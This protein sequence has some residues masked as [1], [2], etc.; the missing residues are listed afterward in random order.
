MGSKRKDFDPVKKVIGGEEAEAVVWSTNS[1]N[2]A[3]DAISKGLPLKANPFVGKNTKLLKPDLVYNRTE[4]EIEDYIHCMNDMVYFA[5]KCYLMTPKGLAPVKLRDYQEDYLRHLSKNRFSLFLSCRQSGKTLTL[6]NKINISFSITYKNEFADLLRKYPFYIK[7]NFYYIDNIPIYEIY[8]HYNKDIINKIRYKLYKSINNKFTNIKYSCISLLDYFEYKVIRKSKL[9]DRYKTI[10][11]NNINKHLFIST[12]T[13]YKEISTITFSKPFKQYY[14]KCENNLECIGAD[15]HRIFKDTLEEVYIKDIQFGDY[16]QTIYGPSKVVLIKINKI[17]ISMCDLCLD[18]PNHRFYSNGILSH[19]STT[20]AI[21]ILHKI[22]FNVDKNGLI[23]SKSGPAGQD[24]LKKTKDMYL[25]LP[26]HLKCGTLKWNQSEISF[27]NNSSLTTEAFSPTAGLGKTINFLILDEFAWCP[28]NDVELFYNN[29]IPTIT[30]DPQAN[31]CIMST[32]NGFNLFYQLWHGAETGKNIYAPFKVDWWQVPN[33]NPETGKWEKRDEKWK[34]TM[35]GV[36]GSPEKFYYQYGTMFSASDKCLVSRECLT[37]IRENTKL[38]ITFKDEPWYIGKH[39]DAFT[40]KEGY[41]ISKD[42]YY[43]VLV[44]LAEGGGGDYTIF[45]IL[46][47]I[48]DSHFEQVA[49][50]HCNTVDLEH[51][52]LEFWLMFGQLFAEDHAIISIEWNTYGALFYMYLSQLNEPDYMVEESWRFNVVTE[53]D[54]SCI[55]RYKKGSQEE[56]IANLPGQSTKHKQIPGIRLTANNKKAAC[57]LLKMKFEKFEIIITDL[58]TVGELENFEDK[59]GNGSYAAGYGHD[60]I[61]M[62][63]AQF[64]MLE[65]TP[66]FKD[67]IEEFKMNKIVNSNSNIDDSMDLYSSMNRS[68]FFDSSNV[69]NK[70]N[71]FY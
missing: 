28:P 70:Y 56:E 50:W 49:K 10:N 48:D 52:A 1:L 21:A 68:L 64:P 5:S 26:Y 69:L 53:L 46:E 23:L 4:E 42:K 30:T 67:F 63:F 45:N 71:R 18:D 7:E 25:Y 35:I 66:K 13:G 11:E 58:T 43:I 37:K 17:S 59:N 65:N 8:Y 2:A 47:V 15:E 22:L 6:I 33:F 57:A 41:Y 51:A 12:D 55:A 32:Q 16:I 36:L 60:D 61:I 31:I 14:I 54:T 39:T 44:D 62:T 19:N 27:D 24:L 20:T 9:I 34:E 29:I 40:Y 3:V 38:F